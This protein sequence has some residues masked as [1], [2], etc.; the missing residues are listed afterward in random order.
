[1]THPGPYGVPPHGQHPTPPP[2]YGRR[3]PAPAYGQYAPPSYGPYGGPPS[4]GYGDVPRP[5][6]P[7]GLA[8]ATAVLA[9]AVT[10][11]Q[12]LA[13]AT[14]FGAAGAFARAARA[15]T[16]SVDV[17]TAYDAV[18]L[19]LLPVQVAAAVVTCVWLWRSRVLAEAVSPGVPHARSR[20]W[21]WLGWLVPVV[22]LW[23]PYQ[24]VRDV[25]RATVA[26]PRPGLG[27]WWA[28]W[29]TWSVASNVATQVTTL[30]T[31]GPAETFSL[32]PVAETVGTVGIVL[33][34]VFWVRTVREITAGQ[35][36]LAGG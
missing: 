16:P 22:A 28:G 19:L 25:R 13:W 24:V 18:G 11:V 10:A 14:S 1:M 34:L 4:A 2:A 8:T 20:V 26:A 9:V 12:V 23:F 21:V 29:L 33:A 6:V 35:R 15:G 7:G 30:S 3:G 17:Y 36:T 32:L 5:P 31:A 27:W